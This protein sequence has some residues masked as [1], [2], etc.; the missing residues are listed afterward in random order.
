MSAADTD[1]MLEEL[2]PAVLPGP[3]RQ[4]VR[5]RAE[6]NPFFVEELVRTLIDQGVLERQQRRAGRRRELPDDLVVPDTV[7]A[8]LAARIDLLDTTEKA[9][10]QAAAVIGRTFWSGPVYELLERRSSRTSASSR[11]GTSSAIGPGRRSPASASSRSS[12]P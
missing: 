11:S 5:E 7:Q 1:R 3:V 6:G 4:L 9:A 10:L 8:V 2:L 12:T